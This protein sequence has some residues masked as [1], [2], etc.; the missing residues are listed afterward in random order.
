MKTETKFKVAFLSVVFVLSMLITSCETT[1]KYS[2]PEPESIFKNFIGKRVM[3]DLY[4]YPLSPY[5][6][7]TISFNTGEINLTNMKYITK[8][9][10]LPFTLTKDSISNNNSIDDIK[11]GKYL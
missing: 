5:N 1:T 9:V 2:D 6:R 10:S 4:F 8:R 7:T 3:K 11:Y